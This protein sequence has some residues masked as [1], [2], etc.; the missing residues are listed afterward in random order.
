[1]FFP[2]SSDFFEKIIVETLAIQISFSL[3]YPKLK[4]SHN[5]VSPNLVIYIFFFL[6]FPGNL[7]IL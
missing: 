4:L 7:R 2:F 3:K 6:E 5:P 1:M